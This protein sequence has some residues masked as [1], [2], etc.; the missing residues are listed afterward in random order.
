MGINYKSVL[1]RPKGTFSRYF[2]TLSL[3]VLIFSVHSNAQVHLERISKTDRSDGL[4]FVVRY[5][6]DTP[7]DSFT[8]IQPAPDLIQMQL[9]SPSI[10]TSGI[11]IPNESGKVKEI[12]LYKLDNSY[13]VDIYLDEKVLVKANAYTDGKSNDVL[14][15]MTKASKYQ[16]ELYTQQF[17]AKTW[18]LNSF[19]KDALEIENITVEPETDDSYNTIADKLKFDTVII[20]PGHGGKDPGAIGYR[21]TKEKDI[22]LAVAKLVGGYIEKYLSDVKVV[23]TR[24]DDTFID[25]YERGNIA[26]ENEGDLFISIHANNFRKSY[27]NGTEIFFLGLHRSKSS[28]EI[29]KK[30]NMIFRDGEQEIVELTEEQLL[31][32]ELANSGYISNSER[33]AAMMDKEFTNR[34]KRKSRGV[35]Q[36]GFVVLY[37]A[38]MPS[39]LVELGFLSNP[40]EQRFLSS[41]KGQK[42][43]ASAIFRSIREYKVEYERSLKISSSQ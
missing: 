30:E 26:N 36:A 38:S 4:G 10:D 25:L 12:R 9:F 34:A 5:H 31:I 33:I 7:I 2:I 17:I 22:A 43:M 21:N 24:D 1:L 32:Y 19:T 27:V 39:V 35:K 42:I 23:Y 20:D 6:F 11:R 28:L 8:V 29:M 18:Y 41:E 40:S 14:L 3:F 13:G 37:E 15:A 16:V